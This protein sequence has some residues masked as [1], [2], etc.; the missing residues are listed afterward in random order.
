MPMYDFE[1]VTCKKTVEL[2]VS[3][4]D[5]DNKMACSCCGEEIRRKFSAVPVI[6][7]CGGFY[8]VDSKGGSGGQK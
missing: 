3:I 5:I 7:K 6:Y 1:C 8:S 4:K 2:S